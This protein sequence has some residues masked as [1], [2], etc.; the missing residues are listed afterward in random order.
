ME[1]LLE[2]LVS[3]GYLLAAVCLGMFLLCRQERLADKKHHETLLNSFLERFSAVSDV[4]LI[5]KDR[6]GRT[7]K[8]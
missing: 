5:I 1:A 2:Y 8:E 4:L 3:K 7:G 6:M